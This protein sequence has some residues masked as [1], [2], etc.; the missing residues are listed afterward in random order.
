MRR[1]TVH[2]ELRL[3]KQHHRLPIYC[4]YR[5]LSLILAEAESNEEIDLVKLREYIG[6]VALLFQQL[7]LRYSHCNLQFGPNLMFE[8][9]ED[10]PTCN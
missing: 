2:V 5:F 4:K 3:G 1:W 8:L 7:N 10:M 6:T 9:L